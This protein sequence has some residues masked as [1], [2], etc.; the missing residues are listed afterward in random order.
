MTSKVNVTV[1]LTDEICLERALKEAGI[2][3]PAS[4]EKLTVTGAFPHDDWYFIFDEMENLKELDI[5]NVSED[6]FDMLPTDNRLFEFLTGL[7]SIAV[8][9]WFF[10]EI[11]VLIDNIADVAE[12]W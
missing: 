7:N 9:G 4:V 12:E 10:N 3:M 2:K 1:C 6:E 5:T 11:Q 8:P